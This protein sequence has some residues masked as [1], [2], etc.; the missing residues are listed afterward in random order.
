MKALFTLFLASAVFG[1]LVLFR[2]ATAEPVPE[3][4]APLAPLPA[5]PAAEPVRLVS[6]QPFVLDEPYTH[7][8]RAE[9]P[10]VTAGY[11][12]VLEADPGLLEPR[13]TLEP[14]LYVGNETAER[15][16]AGGQSGRL[17]VIVPA[18]LGAGGAPALDPTA[19]P[20]WFGDP[21]LP[22]SV[23]AAEVAVQ[24]AKAEATGVAPQRAALAAGQRLATFYARDRTELDLAV[25]D[26]IERHSPVE[27][28]LIE[29]LRVPVTR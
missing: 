19:V 13:Q 1:A 16:N 11:L 9:Q 27:R 6:A 22:E 20:I 28:D 12:L 5:E 3:E 26:H 2:N 25:A 17:V 14:V 18:S 23:D 10:S 21:A 29:G 4:P 24:R 15:C 8:W 7:W